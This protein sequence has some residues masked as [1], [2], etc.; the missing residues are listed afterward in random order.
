MDSQNSGFGSQSRGDSI[1]S[2]N[3]APT[4][5]H[6]TQAAQYGLLANMFSQL[7]GPDGDARKEQQMAQETSFIT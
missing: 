1:Q 7:T 5:G 4:Y 2:S 6:Q 3:Q